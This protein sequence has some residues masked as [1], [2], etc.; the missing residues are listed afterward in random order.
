[1]TVALLPFWGEGP[2]VEGCSP[3]AQPEHLEGAEDDLKAELGEAQGAPGLFLCHGSKH[4]L[5][6]TQQGHQRQR[7]ASQ[8][9]GG[10]GRGW[11]WS[12]GPGSPI[13]HP[14]PF[15]FV[16]TVLPLPHLSR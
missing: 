13:L 4:H 7:G 8:P 3:C 9:G 5:V 14:E 16:P 2:Q 10:S 11:Q 12:R 15:P 1:M 6:D